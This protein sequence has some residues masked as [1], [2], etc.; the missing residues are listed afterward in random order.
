MQDGW[1][2]DAPQ[3]W[4]DLQ[5]SDEAVPDSHHGTVGTTTDLDPSLATI[6]P[7]ISAR[8]PCPV[9]GGHTRNSSPLT[10]YYG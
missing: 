6:G 1:V 7:A 4:S 10:E 9:R 2:A 5:Y 3:S 8:L